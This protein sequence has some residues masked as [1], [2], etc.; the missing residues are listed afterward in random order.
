M[1]P[2]RLIRPSIVCA[3]VSRNEIIL[4]LVAL[5]LVVF[6]LVV[7]LVVS[8]RNPAFPGK[9][10][11]LFL[12]V[13]IGLVAGML[14]TVE[15][16]GGEEEQE[17][18]AAE[19]GEPPAAELAPPAPEPA[20]PPA[21]EPAPPAAPAGDPAAG[22]ELVAANGCGSC[23]TLADAGASGA[24]GPNLDEARPSVDLVVERVTN[25]KA[26][27]PAFAGTLSDTQIADVAAYV[28]HAT[29]G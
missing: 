11:R 29:S 26:P 5:V 3:L 9:N 19:V 1:I 17:A 14:A 10:L 24:I 13:A 15:V 8:R 23:H 27:M 18:E 21:A 2:T 28:V 7:S 12:L 6:S 22:K 20:A 16:V 25:G 4:G